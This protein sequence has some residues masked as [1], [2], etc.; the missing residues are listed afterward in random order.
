MIYPSH[1]RPPASAVFKNSSTSHQ[2]PV[3]ISLRMRRRPGHSSRYIHHVHVRQLSRALSTQHTLTNNS[4]QYRCAF[5]GHQ[6][7][8]LD[9]FITFT[10][11][12]SRGRSEVIKSSSTAH[13]NIIAHSL[14]ARPHFSILS[15][16]SRSP[17][18]ADF[19]HESRTRHNIIA[20]A[21]TTRA[22][23]STHSSHSRPPAS[24]VFES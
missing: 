3:A 2:Q 5:A 11:A 6:A 15:S 17:A 18:S 16:H 22:Q 19:K 10:F 9:T 13:H 8:V 21:L 20:H 1:S 4:S 24:V 12:S 7:T 23:L 14:T